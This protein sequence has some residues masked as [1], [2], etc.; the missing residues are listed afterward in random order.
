VVEVAPPELVD[1]PELV[2]PDPPD[3]P[4][5][6]CVDDSSSLH[7]AVARA[8]SRTLGPTW[9]LLMGSWY[10]KEILERV[11]A[12]LVQLAPALERAV[13]DAPRIGKGGGGAVDLRQHA[14]D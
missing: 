13:A 12:V 4:G 10:Q 14:P 5:L 8:R 9:W 3:P 1:P 11:A 7:A 6:P 2:A